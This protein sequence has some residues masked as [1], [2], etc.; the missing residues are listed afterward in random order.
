[1]VET[2]VASSTQEVLIGDNGFTVLIGERINPSGK[3]K[4]AVALKAGDMDVVRNEALSQVEAGA[5]ILDVNVVTSGVDEISLLPRVVETITESVQVPLSIDIN[6]PKALKAALEVYDGKPIINSVNGEEASLNTIL[7][8]VK[9]YDTAVIGL[10]MDHNGIPKEPGRRL[11]IAGKIIE[12]AETFG[13]SREAII[14]DC[15]ALTVGADYHAALATIE[16]IK[17]VRDQLGVNQTLGASNISF[18]LPDRDIVNHA[19]LAIAIQ[20]GVTC[21]TVDVAKVRPA[22]LATDLL[23]GRDRFAQRFLRDYNRRKRQE[24]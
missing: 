9:E 16:A 4:L 14:I 12:T 1:M 19:F 21:P 24:K 20:A 15:L 17:K 3:K 22:V 18:G 6:N 23:M 10:T 5:D 13:I 7:P 8:L 2:R 11:E